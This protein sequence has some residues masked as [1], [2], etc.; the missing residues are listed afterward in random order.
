MIVINDIYDLK[1]NLNAKSGSHVTVIADHAGILIVQDDKGNRF[2][3]KSDNLRDDPEPDK[4][5][6]DDAE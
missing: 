3:A 4:K 5:T 6:G 1:K 2:P